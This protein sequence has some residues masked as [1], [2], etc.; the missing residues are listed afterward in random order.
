MT[1]NYSWESVIPCPPNSFGGRPVL[2]SK[3][4]VTQEDDVR[5]NLVELEGTRVPFNKD[6]NLA[7]CQWVQQAIGQLDQLKKEEMEAIK[8]IRFGADMA[9]EAISLPRFSRQI[10]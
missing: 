10:T 2:G 6:T 4:V 8:W 3:S 9:D 7:L 5:E 1:I